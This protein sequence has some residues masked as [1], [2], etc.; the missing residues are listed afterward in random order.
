MEVV[1]RG[2][3]WEVELGVGREEGRRVGVGVRWR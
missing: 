3:G 2:G 1:R